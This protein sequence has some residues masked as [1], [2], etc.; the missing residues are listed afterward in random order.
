MRGFH[1]AENL[2]GLIV[3]LLEEVNSMDFDERYRQEKEFHDKKSENAR[4]DFYTYGVLDRANRYAYD[5][6]GDLQDLVVLDLGC[7]IGH[8]CLMLAERGAMVYA[9][10]LS[11]GMVKKTKKRI[12]ENGLDDRIKVLQMNAEE[13]QFNDETFDIVFGHSILH[14]THL[15]ITRGEVHRVL[16]Q[17]G[18]GVFFEPLGHNA[19]MNLF[20]KLT[21]SR[22][23][24]SEKPLKIED[25]VFFAEPFSALKHREFYLLALISFPLLPFNREGGVRWVFNRLSRLDD[26]LFSHWPILSR[27][28]WV[29][30]F[31]VIK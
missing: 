24:P 19:L 31:E 4:A 15:E 17:G 27:Y 26:G 6:L 22:R 16:R 21:P 8:H 14:H 3:S 11:A 1:D 10:D 9:V 25:L 28:G 29:T 7:G 23:T 30:V 2:L 18:K 12:K 20:R 13:L 5:L